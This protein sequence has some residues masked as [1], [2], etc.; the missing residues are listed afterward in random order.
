MT[1]KCTKIVG[2]T[3]LDITNA[4]MYAM[5][6][7]KKEQCTDPDIVKKYPGIK[8]KS[9]EENRIYTCPVVLKDKCEHGSCLLSSKESCIAQSQ[10]PGFLSDGKTRIKEDLI[11]K[12][13]KDGCCASYEGQCTVTCKEDTDCSNFFKDD[14]GSTYVCNKNTSNGES[15]SCTTTKPYLEWRDGQN[16]ED[17]KCIYGNFI[18][19]KW[20]ENPRSRRTEATRGATDVPAFKYDDTTGK[21]NITKEYCD[22]MGV[23][24]KDGDRPDCYETTGQKTGEFVLGKT[25]FRGIPKL[26]HSIGNLIEGF[27][28]LPNEINNL[29]DRHSAE[30]YVE[31]SKDFGG[32]GINLYQ[33][34]WKPDCENKQLSTVGFFADEIEKVYPQ[35]IKNKSGVKYIVVNRNH[36][37]ENP[38]IK[39]IYVVAGSGRWLMDNIIEMAKKLKT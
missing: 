9:K 21:C 22:W 12:D 31:I 10:K 38:K 35:L 29:A 32:V 39:R 7:I 26:A 1:T 5:D 2:P 37:K 15:P 24:Y 20:C 4:M 25:I 28:N 13:K 6:R 17:G 16:G 3:P 8:W 23:S 34:I 33:I 36:L 30:H 14:P 11:C 19:Q 18:A 27:N